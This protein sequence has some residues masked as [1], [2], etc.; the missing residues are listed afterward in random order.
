MKKLMLTV[1]AAA[2]VA[3]SFAACEVKDA[4]RAKRMEWWT[5]ARFG[6]FI[7]F[8]LYALPA[9]HEW[10][11]SIEQIPETEYQRYWK[12]DRELIDLLVSCVANGGNLILNVG[13]TGR[14]E[15]DGR[16]KERLAQIGAW[17]DANGEAIYGCTQAPAELKVPEKTYLTWNPKTKRLFL[18]LPEYAG[19]ELALAFAGRVAYA[20]FLHDA[21]E[22]ALKDGKL[23]LPKVKP[24]Q[25]VPVVEL[26]L[27]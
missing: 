15:F 24:N 4:E 1:V 11:K 20:K 16:A 9:R 2:M 27:K 26:E 8:G 21:S 17:M 14:G 3:G 6:L 7:H 12:T 23:Q 18:L 13:P 5:D 25:S 19:G 10:V 22:I